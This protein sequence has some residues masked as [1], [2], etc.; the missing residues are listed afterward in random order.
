MNSDQMLD[1]LLALPA[2]KYRPP[3]LHPLV[4]PDGR[5]VAWT[6]Y[7]TGL[8]ADV[9]AAATDGSAP[10]VRLTETPNDTILI[11]WSPDSRAVVVEEDKNGN[12]RTRLFR[13]DLDCPLEMIPLTQEDP[14]YYLRRGEL[15]PNGRWLVYGANV[16]TSSGQEIEVTWIYR[17]DLQSGERVVLA[18]P[19]KPGYTWLALSPD[20]RHVL[21]TRMDQHP[22]GRQIW[23]ADIEGQH[24]REI[25][26]CGPQ[27]KAL[28]YWFPDGQRVLVVAEAEGKT[29][30]RVGVWRL[31]DGSLRWLID[32]PIRTIAFASAP[33][34]T[35]RLAI[36]EHRDARMRASLLG[37]QTGE[38]FPLPE[39]PG[40][41]VP[42]GAT[43]D[44]AW[45]GMY[46]SATYPND[47][48]RFSPDDPRP[49]AFTS[50]SRVWDRT[51]LTPADFT[52]AG[53]FHW[54]SVD[55]M[56]M[57]GWLYRPGEESRGTIVYIHGGP[58]T[59]SEDRINREFA[60]LVRRG[61][62]VF[63][64]NYR[65]STGFSLAHREAIK[66]DGWGG[67][68]QDDIRT[69]IQ[70]LIQAGIA[71]PGKVGITGTSFG[72]YS[73]WWAITHFPL[74]IIA[75]AAPICGIADLVADYETIPAY[76]RPFAAEMIGGRPD[77]I[78]D[79]YRERSPIHFVQNIQGKLLIVQGM[80]D[81]SVTQEIV[82][83]VQQ[84]L[85]E[86][87]I[88]YQLLAFE[89]EGHG[90]S[91]PANQKTLNLRLDKFFGSAF[92]T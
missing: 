51:S 3:L 52:P 67:R 37:V 2:I 32:D 64:P 38:E 66:V 7:G 8:A 80:Q 9:F 58:T 89:D 49:E 43:P 41:L 23:L 26:N 56:A 19:Q 74:E 61:Y 5:W 31:S 73:A 1:A 24:D 71:Q 21:Y 62:T 42:L 22:A 35:D 29:H 60:F 6:W 40:N 78:P 84:A 54:T 15:H 72:G 79:K 87:G 50:L 12:Q 57:Q 18:R 90:I 25:V 11:S 46:Y 45:V 10:P 27:V 76:M 81:P 83:A 82:R 55:G 20:G 70:A 53:E 65:G 39:I 91:K 17:H 77:E 63:D 59:H 92:G 85:E 86:A 13:V 88:D 68:E 69:G 36:I 33:A 4:S 44:G 48:V 75:A 16:D 34:H 30:V 28:A 47:L 14:N